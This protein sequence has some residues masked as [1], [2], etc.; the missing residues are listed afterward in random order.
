MDKTR[1]E[2]LSSINQNLNKPGEPDREVTCYNG[3][4]KGIHYQIKNWVDKGLP[5]YDILESTHWTYYLFIP[6]AMLQDVEAKKKSTIF[7]TLKED[8]TFGRKRKRY[9]Y[10]SDSLLA[11]L[12]WHGGITYY[13][14]EESN[15]DRCVKAGCD[16]QHSWDEGITY[17][18]SNLLVD[19]KHTVDD[20]IKQVPEMRIR[21]VWD[22]E[23][24]PLSEALSATD[25]K[26]LENK[27]EI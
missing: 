4:Y 20:F 11:D 7:L 24:Y 12:H 23:Y 14:I 9:D 15:G 25:P 21:S 19:I 5:K 13:D 27:N 3:S 22:G 1:E 2:I 16:F 18:V 10:Y 17:N 8:D 6:E 26:L